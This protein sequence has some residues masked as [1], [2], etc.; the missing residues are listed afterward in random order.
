M[1]K[2]EAVLR[3]YTSIK[4]LEPHTDDPPHVVASKNYYQHLK[5]T[6]SKSVVIP[7]V[8]SDNSGQLLATLENKIKEIYFKAVWLSDEAEEEPKKAA[9]AKPRPTVMA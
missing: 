4:N 7:P 1:K 5:A 3:F 2:K 9:K 8:I 6:T